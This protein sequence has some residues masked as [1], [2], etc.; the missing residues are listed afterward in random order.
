MDCGDN[1]ASIKQISNRYAAI[2]FDDL[3]PAGLGAERRIPVGK[4]SAN[5]MLI[6]GVHGLGLSSHASV[7]AVP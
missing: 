4:P 5:L 1:A 7:A 6:S 2:I 3:F